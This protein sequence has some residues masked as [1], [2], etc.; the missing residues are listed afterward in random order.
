MPCT[1]CDNSQCRKTRT[2]SVRLA[3]DVPVGGCGAS[4]LLKFCARHGTGRFCAGIKNLQGCQPKSMVGAV[5]IGVVVMAVVV[6]I[7]VS[8][9]VVVVVMVVVIV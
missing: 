5:V 6:A 8:D 7:D 2:G 3:A 9:L 4:S 1:N